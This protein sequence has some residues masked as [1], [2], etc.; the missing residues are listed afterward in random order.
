[1]SVQDFKKYKPSLLFIGIVDLFHKYLISKVKIVEEDASKTWTEQLSKHIRNNDLQIMEACR[2][3]LKD[4]EE[5]LIVCEDWMEMFDVLGFL[6][7]ISDPQEFLK[8]YL[9]NFAK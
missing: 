5:D 9:Q 1:M 2:K 4:F 6:D 7:E 8:N 3:V